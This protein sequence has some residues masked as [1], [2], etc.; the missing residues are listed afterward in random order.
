MFLSKNMQT[1]LFIQAFERRG[2]CDLIAGVD[3]PD[4]LGRAFESALKRVRFQYDCSKWNSVSI[5]QHTSDPT[6]MSQCLS[7]IETLSNHHLF[8]GRTV[9]SFVQSI[10]QHGP[11]FV[12]VKVKYNQSL[13]LSL[14]LNLVKRSLNQIKPNVR[15][16]VRSSTNETNLMTRPL[17]RDMVDHD[18]VIGIR[19]TFYSIGLDFKHVQRVISPS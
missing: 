1:N 9:L 14:S 15:L 5:Q 11:S 4:H 10:D 17:T 6:S 2:R 12:G 7:I 8:S 18:S 13:S 19:M 3:I 16:E